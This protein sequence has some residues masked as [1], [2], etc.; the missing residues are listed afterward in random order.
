MSTCSHLAHAAVPGRLPAPLSPPRPPARPRHPAQPWRLEVKREV[1]TAQASAKVRASLRPSV[2]LEAPELLLCGSEDC[3]G[4]RQ[5]VGE[6]RMC[7]KCKHCRSRS[8]SCC[9]RRACVLRSFLWTCLLL[10]VPT[11]LCLPF[12]RTL[13]PLHSTSGGCEPQGGAPPP[14]GCPRGS[15]RPRPWRGVEPGREPARVVRQNGGGGGVG[16]GAG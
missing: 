11:T 15:H 7:A 10:D 6:G 13:S 4:E 2:A 3:R 9:C 1:R 12:T 8:R 14:R 5:G 16:C